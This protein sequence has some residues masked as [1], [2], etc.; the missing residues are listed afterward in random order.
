MLLHFFLDEGDGF[1]GDIAAVVIEALE[2]SEEGEERVSHSAAKFVVV[3]DLPRQLMQLLEVCDLWHFAFE[4]GPVLEEVAFVEL[5]ELVPDLVAACSQSLV[6]LL[7]DK[8]VV[9]GEF[10]D[11]FLLHLLGQLVE[12]HHLLGPAAL[13]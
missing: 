8:S 12:D 9:F 1:F 5:V 10:A 4:V 11:C 13:V 6:V 3:A 2:L 7:G